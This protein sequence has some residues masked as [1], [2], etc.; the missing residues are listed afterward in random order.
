DDLAEMERLLRQLMT[1]KPEDPQ[2]YNALGYALADRGQRLP[3]ARQLI[4]KALTLSPGDP[5]I[6]DSLA[7]VAFRMGQNEEALQL[8][9]NAFKQKPDAEIA[10]HLGEVLWV[11]AQP[12]EARKIWREGLQINPDND[13]LKATLQRLRVE[14]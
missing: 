11:T 2:A 9:S 10:A 4:E 12:D 7:W 6:M 8:L 14:L 5:F 1:L 13:T 3:E